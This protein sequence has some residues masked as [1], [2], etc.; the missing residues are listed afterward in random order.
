MSYQPLP[1]Q[2]PDYYYQSEEIVMASNNRLLGE[3]AEIAE[4]IQDLTKLNSKLERML[5]KIGA[6]GDDQSF[7]NLMERQRISAK[8]LSREIMTALKNHHSSDKQVFQKLTSQFQAALTNFNNINQE[9]EKKQNRVV[10]RMSVSVASG[11][12]R[13][14]AEAMTAE[15]GRL[16]DKQKLSID[17]GQRSESQQQADQ[18]LDQ[19]FAFETYNEEE[20]RARKEEIIQIERDVVE[21]AEM[22]KDLHVLVGEQQEHIDNIESNVESAREHTKQGHEELVQAEQYQ[23][24]ARRKQC[25]ILF[26]ILAVV[27]IIV[28]VLKVK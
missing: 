12:K 5:A 17:S 2:I 26:I 20:L 25:C 1:Q 27:G 13:I 9:I 23:K 8:N 11:N 19:D 15:T 6:K 18:L 24:K 10:Q 3:N 14:S 7:R 22:F 16:L 28:L 21:V 4:K